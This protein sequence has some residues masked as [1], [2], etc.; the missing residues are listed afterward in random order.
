MRWR[1]Q[2]LNSDL[3]VLSLSEDRTTWKEQSNFGGEDDKLNKSST[4]TDDAEQKALWCPRVAQNAS[5]SFAPYRKRN[6]LELTNLAKR[7]LKAS[8]CTVGKSKFSLVVKLSLLK[9][10]AIYLVILEC[11]RPLQK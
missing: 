1:K 9:S 10:D 11:L 2:G 7:S 6:G 8:T 5:Q 4:R 3:V